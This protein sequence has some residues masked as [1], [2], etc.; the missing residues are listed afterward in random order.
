MKL[1]FKIAAI[2]LVISLFALAFYLVSTFVDTANAG[3]HGTF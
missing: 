3:F 2:V 1:S